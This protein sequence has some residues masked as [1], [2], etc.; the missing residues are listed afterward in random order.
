MKSRLFIVSMLAVLSSCSSVESVQKNPACVVWK[1]QKYLGPYSIEVKESK[2]EWNGSCRGAHWKC[3]NVDISFDEN[4]NVL[5][6]T[7][8][9]GKIEGVN[10]NYSAKSVGDDQKS[11]IT[12]NALRA[13]PELKEVRATIAKADVTEEVVYH[14]ND[15]CS[16]DQGIIGGIALGMVEEIRKEK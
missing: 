1:D 8:S 3:R 14:Y 2:V 7:E 11:L 10:F 6:A 5:L 16:S 4:K 12:Y 15:K 9:I 13:Y